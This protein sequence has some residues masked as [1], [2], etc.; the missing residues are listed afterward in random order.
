MLKFNGDM[1]LNDD[2][3]MRDSKHFKIVTQ[4]KRN[5]TPTEE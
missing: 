5:N 1:S 4:L 2:S 3:P